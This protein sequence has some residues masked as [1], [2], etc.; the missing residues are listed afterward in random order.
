MRL[1]FLIPYDEKYRKVSQETYEDMFSLVKRRNPSAYEIAEDKEIDSLQ[2]LLIMLKLG[3]LNV[4]TCESL[5]KDEMV[6]LE[7]TNPK[8]ILINYQEK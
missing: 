5:D 4:N 7:I 6:V 1:S 2:D 8:E 3:L